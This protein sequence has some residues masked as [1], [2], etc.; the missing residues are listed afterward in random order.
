M[1]Q[2]SSSVFYVEENNDAGDV[3]DYILL[4]FPLLES[5]THQVF[6]CAFSIALQKVRIYD[7]S[8]LLIF[9]ELPD[10]VTRQNDDLIRRCHSKLGNLGNGI[11]TDPS[12]NLVTEGA[13]HSQTWNVFIFEPNALRSN[14]IPLAVSIRIDTTTSSVNH[15]RFLRVIWFVISR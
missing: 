7:V 10:A 8:D 1:E 4:A 5:C 11:D 15:L 13:T 12:S 9:E 2:L 3:I 6:S 14:F